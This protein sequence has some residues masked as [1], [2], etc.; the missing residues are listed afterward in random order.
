LDYS[1]IVISAHNCFVLG[2]IARHIR[3]YRHIREHT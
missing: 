2:T 3:Y 1:D